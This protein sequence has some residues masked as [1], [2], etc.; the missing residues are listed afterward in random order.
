MA[1]ENLL[2]YYNFQ[3]ESQSQDQLLD[4]WLRSYP[5]RWV[6][7]ALIEALYQGRYKSISVELLLQ[8]WQRRGEPIYHFNG[9]FETLVCHNVPQTFTSLNSTDPATA[10]PQLVPV[11]SLQPQP[12]SAAAAAAATEPTSPLPSS[13]KSTLEPESDLSEFL[14]FAPPSQRFDIEVRPAP[15]SQP[16]AEERVTLAVDEP[17]ASDGDWLTMELERT[18]VENVQALVKNQTQEAQTSPI[19]YFMPTEQPTGLYARL[20]AIANAQ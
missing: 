7:L 16:P 3:D 11:E 14:N 2:T 13:R 19:R 12:S 18:A 15:E 10:S 6:R 1:T 5:A 8:L 20:A 9:E 17:E 4:H